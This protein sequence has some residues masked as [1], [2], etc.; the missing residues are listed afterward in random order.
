MSL[1]PTRGCA[2]SPV[3]QAKFAAQRSSILICQLRQQHPHAE[4]A[5]LLTYFD[6]SY[7]ASLEG[8]I[9]M[10]INV[11]GVLTSGL[12]AG[13]IINVSA[14]F[15][16]PVVGNQM[17]EALKARNVPPMGGGAMAYFGVMS[18]VLGV[19]LVWLYAAVRPRLGPGPKTAAIVSILVWFLAYFFANV[20]NVVFGFMPLHLTVMGTVWGLV[21]LLVAGEVG[22][23]LYNEK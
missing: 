1:V 7:H 6:Q 18:F 20:S 23:R 16:V 8:E 13:L 22:A 5:A 14:I 19:I 3:A 9:Q 11:K 15:M 12:V 4:G 2:P 17:E 10:A 21:E